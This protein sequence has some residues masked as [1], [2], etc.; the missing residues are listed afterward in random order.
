MSSNVVLIDLLGAGALLLWG[1]RMVKTGVTRAFG[2]RLRHW[3]ALGT[4]NRFIAFSVG[5]AATLIVQSSTATALMTASF[6]GQELISAAMGQAIM[7]GANVGTSLVTQILS[8]DISWLSPLLIL[9]G[10]ATFQ[11]GGSSRHHAIGRAILGLGLMLLSLHLLGAATDP[12]RDSA[13][14]RSLLSTLDAAPVVAVIIAAGLAIVASSS[15]AV[16]LFVMSLATGGNISPALSLAL[17]LGANLGG[18]VPPYLA[19]ASSG[20][21]ARRI[22]LGNFTVRLCGTIVVMAF[23]DPVAAWLSGWQPNEARMV[24]DAHVAL[25]MALA[26]IFL[27]LIGPLADI[28]ERLLPLPK[29]TDTG[30]RYLDNSAFDTPAVALSCA[31]RETLR[32]GDLIEAMLQTSLEAL[33]TGDLKLC[34]AVGKQENQVD[35]LYQAVKLYLVHLGREGLDDDDSKRS[36]EVMSYAINLE[37]IGDILERG[38]T[39]LVSKKIKQ[40]VWFSD[41]GFKEISQMYAMTIENFHIAQGLF[42]SRDINLARKLLATKSVVHDFERESYERH[43]QRLQEGHPE[44]MQTSTLHLD[45]L[46]DLR[47]INAHIR[48]VVYPVLD[49]TT[50]REKHSSEEEE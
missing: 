28:A 5:L 3:L 6:V 14:M 15:L 40:Q 39:E 46:R 27:P 4:K 13:V 37:H 29:T 47:R 2:G 1:L 30:P 8:L 25:N 49:E 26:I 44:T 10:V 48:S 7:L 34:S 18:A 31:A 21:L 42:V 33:K 9:I 22:T 41:A 23:L 35:K 36:A 45:V 32:I 43:L 24:V 20:V 19:T 11:S 16:V 12:I 17:V 50:E 38:L